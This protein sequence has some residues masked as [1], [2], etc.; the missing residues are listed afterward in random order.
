MK[1]ANFVLGFSLLLAV[2]VAAVDRAIN[3]VEVYMMMLMCFGFIIVIPGLL[4][5]VDFYNRTKSIFKRPKLQPGEPEHSVPRFYPPGARTL[6]NIAGFA[7]W[8]YSLNWNAW[9]FNA[10]SIW[11]W[12][13]YATPAM[14]T[15]TPSCH[16]SFYLFGL[17][18]VNKHSVQFFRIMSV[19]HMILIAFS[20]AGPKLEALFLNIVSEHG[21][22][23]AMDSQDGNEDHE[24]LESSENSTPGM[25]QDP[26]QNPTKN[27]IFAAIQFSACLEAFSVLISLASLVAFIE[28]TIS[29]ANINGVY[30]IRSTG[31]LLPFVIGIYSFH[32]ILRKCVGKKIPTGKIVSCIRVTARPREIY[33]KP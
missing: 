15:P 30:E 28:A 2:T 9:Y 20:A 22:Q 5:V 21:R 33:N 16:S 18:T 3:L 4:N 23:N 26:G 14:I 6:N 19:I 29:A 12:W 13:S 25:S 31:Q 17:R 8:L 1:T 27:S 7:R 32:N 10:L 11:I 24:K